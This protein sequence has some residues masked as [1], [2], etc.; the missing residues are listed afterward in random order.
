[1]QRKKID[2]RKLTGQLGINL[3]ER[4]AL[5]MGFAWHATNSELDAGID[6]YI[7]I[8]DP[9][10]E[11]ATNCIVQVQSR[12]RREF[13][14][15]TATSFEYLC[16]ERDLR[17]WTEGNA[18]VILVV[19]RSRSDEAYWVSVKQYFEDPTRKASR[20][21]VFDKT[22][23]RFTEECRQQ[24]ID[25][26]VPVDS[27]IYF[28]PLPKAERLISNLLPVTHYPTQ[29]YSGTTDARYPGQIWARAKELGIRIGGEWLLKG[30]QLISFHD[31]REPPWEEFCDR[32]NVEIDFT[33]DWARKRCGSAKRFCST[34]HPMSYG[35]GVAPAHRLSKKPRNL[36]FPRNRRPKTKNR[37]I[38]K[39]ETKRR[40]DSF[41]R[42]RKQ[43]NPW[44]N[45]VLSPQCIRGI[46][47]TVRRRMVSRSHAHILLLL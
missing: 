13:A 3:I 25:L 33:V 1:M 40:Q 28:A 23:Q 8:R 9:I 27:G 35:E 20:R 37:R 11:E 45:C 47:S 38:S 24:L 46:F 6:G 43:D 15:E 31:L 7:E 32:G 4:I 21:I 18:P 30:K 26:A 12:A 44:S 42:L 36:L 17:Y 5:R 19:S 22:A 34:S 14:S 10:S 2:Q 39:L 16:E 29:V 41:R